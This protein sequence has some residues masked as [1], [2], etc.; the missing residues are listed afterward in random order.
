MDRMEILE[1]GKVSFTYMDKQDEE[2][3]G[4]EPGD[5]EG[6]V[7]I[8]RDIEGV[9]VN[10]GDDDSPFIVSIYVPKKGSVVAESLS[11]KGIYVSTK[12]ACSSKKEMS[13]YV[14]EAYGKNDKIAQ[15]SIRISFDRENTLSEVDEFL[16]VL[17]QILIE[18]K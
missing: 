14:L 12:S 3:V 17:K 2:E 11:N 9:E 15:N 6:L 13:S 1:D 4:A 16:R 10:S 8:G 5:H 18:I 7:E